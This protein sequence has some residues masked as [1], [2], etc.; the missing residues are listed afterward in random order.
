MKRKFSVIEVVRVLYEHDTTDEQELEIK[1]IFNDN[2]SEWLKE[3]TS[4]VWDN[5]IYETNLDFI[6]THEESFTEEEF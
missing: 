3:N 6:E 5:A 1:E 4:V 2:Y